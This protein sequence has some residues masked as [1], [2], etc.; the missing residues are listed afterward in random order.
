MVTRAFF[1]LL[2]SCLDTDFVRAHGKDAPAAYPEVH[3]VTVPLRR[4][5]VAADRA[6]HLA[7]WAGTGWREARAVPAATVVAELAGR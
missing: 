5:S 4:A 3:H 1:G 7:L 2:P 6:E